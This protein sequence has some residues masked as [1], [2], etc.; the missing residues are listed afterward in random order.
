M[1]F[2]DKVAVLVP[3]PSQ[4]PST[5]KPFPEEVERIVDEILSEEA[6]LESSRDDDWNL[7]STSIS[8]ESSS[9]TLSSA[10]A[11][12]SSQKGKTPLKPFNSSTTASTSKAPKETNPSSQRR[13]RAA[14]RTITVVNMESDSE[15]EDVSS[16]GGDDPAEENDVTSAMEYNDNVDSNATTLANVPTMRTPTQPEIADSQ[17]D[18]MSMIDGDNAEENVIF[19]SVSE[20]AQLEL[21]TFIGGHQFMLESA[22]P[23]RKSTRRQF[24]AEVREKAQSAGMPDEAIYGLI[25][26][27]RR[28][29]LEFAGV[30][31]ERLL[32]FADDI[33]FGVEI[34]DEVEQASSKGKRK[35][36]SKSL[37]KGEEKVKKRKK[38]KK[39]ISKEL[40]VS[41]QP[42]VEA[43]ALNENLST[44]IVM[45][46]PVKPEQSG[47]NILPQ[48]DEESDDGP[49]RI[50]ESPVPAPAVPTQEDH[51]TDGAPDIIDLTL[52]DNDEPDT[53]DLHERCSTCYDTS[54]EPDFLDHL[55]QIDTPA[56]GEK[57]KEEDTHD[58]NEDGPVISQHH[59]SEHG[60]ANEEVPEPPSASPLKSSVETRRLSTPERGSE[61]LKSKSEI[62]PAQTSSPRSAEKEGSPKELQAEASSPQARKVAI[63][64]SSAPQLETVQN[65]KSLSKAT[66]AGPSSSQPPPRPSFSVESVQTPQSEPITHIQKHHSKEPQ[67]QASSPQPPNLEPTQHSHP[68]NSAQAEPNSQQPLRP[69]SSLE[70]VQNTQPESA[71]KSHKRRTKKDEAEAST[72]QLSHLQPTQ[73]SQPES[74][75]TRSKSPLQGPFPQAHTDPQSDAESAN[76]SSRDSIAFDKKTAKNKRRRSNRRRNRIKRKSEVPVEP[77]ERSATPPQ[78]P[79]RTE[80]PATPVSQN[81]KGNGRHYLHEALSPNPQE[82]DVDF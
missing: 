53:S 77:T 2:T 13:S 32:D 58:K 74:T 34:D 26:Y 62:E 47:V 64:P 54:P 31:P 41:V 7:T 29:Y 36:R 39:R 52:S 44:E 9:G 37:D 17:D 71:T 61:V 6:S 24:T 5:Y 60:A 69:S 10:V 33:P 11:G 55:M 35:R 27:I 20:S 1:D 25:H 38:S 67:P 12:P 81:S 42:L 43:E 28:L 57:D 49:D 63:E 73:Y 78:S 14:R 18:Q 82:W 48:H 65:K 75:K 68:E 23:V 46:S 70:P 72:S 50:P 16:K 15:E 30:E 19:S 21:L 4:D 40:D 59:D 3:P 76:G 79:A 22:Q 80:L 8:D 66:C 56:A 51:K 45:Q